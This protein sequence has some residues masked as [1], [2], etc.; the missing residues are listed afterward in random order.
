MTTTLAMTPDHALAF[1]PQGGEVESAA[2]SV[3]FKLLAVAMV[4]LAL[5]WAWQMASKGLIEWTL[6]SAGWMGAALAMMAYTEW[7]ILTGKTTLSSTHL[8]QTWVWNKQ[9]ALS[10]LAYAKLIRLPGLDWLIAPRLYTRTFSNK[11]AVFYAASP[12]MLAE[13]RR[14]EHTLQS[15]R[16]SARN[17]P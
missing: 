2:F 11:L 9:V 14:L 1:T 12:A 8:K 6:Q 3:P 15:L 5:A 16:A 17:T 4:T 7:H 10:D 13:F